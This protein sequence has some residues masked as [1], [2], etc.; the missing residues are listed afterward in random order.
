MSQQ[1]FEKKTDATTRLECI[2]RWQCVKYFFFLDPKQ[3]S[4]I[5]CNTDNSVSKVVYFYW[6]FR[7]STSDTS[8]KDIMHSRLC[9]ETIP[10]SKKH[11]SRRF[12]CCCWINWHTKPKKLF[13]LCWMKNCWNLNGRILLR[14]MTAGSLGGTIS[15]VVSFHLSGRLWIHTKSS[16]SSFHL[17]IGS[18][19]SK[20]HQVLKRTVQASSSTMVMWS[21]PW[22]WMH[23]MHKKNSTSI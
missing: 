20:T 14:L 7:W 9:Y 6:W 10:R 3:L 18:R 22:W 8:R 4:L 15:S 17:M 11:A 2:T 13:L 23:S 12:R 21:W 16:G 5:I 19:H 1:N